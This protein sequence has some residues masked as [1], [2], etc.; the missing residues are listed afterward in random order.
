[1]FK[2]ETISVTNCTILRHFVVSH[3]RCT[4]EQNS[5]NRKDKIRNSSITNIVAT[6]NNMHIYLCIQLLYIFPT[7]IPLMCIHMNELV[8]L[9]FPIYAYT[10]MSIKVHVSNNCIRKCIHIYVL[11]CIY[12]HTY[13]YIHMYMVTE[14]HLHTPFSLQII[15]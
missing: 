1:M 8:D 10:Y 2:I 3:T 6:A 13:K 12:I 15:I 14:Y 7:T 11:I 4:G 5:D 9:Y